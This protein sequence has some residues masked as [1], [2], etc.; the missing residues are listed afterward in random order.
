M[1]VCWPIM[2]VVRVG[3]ELIM[4]PFRLQVNERGLSPLLTLHVSCTKSPWLTGLSPNVKGTNSGN[5]KQQ[6]LQSL[7]P[8]ILFIL[9]ASC[10]LPGKYP[11]V[12]CEPNIAMVDITGPGLTDKH[13]LTKVSLISDLSVLGSVNRIFPSPYLSMF[14]SFTINFQL[15]RIHCNPCSIL[16][17]AGID[18]RVL[19][20]HRGYDQYAG[21]SAKH[22]GGETGVRGY[23]V[24]LQTP[25]DRYGH[26]ATSNDA[27]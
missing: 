25:G 1:L 16:S 6:I 10:Q 3:S 2:V 11:Y 20:I 22:S 9:I 15:C 5:S 8:F 26:V 13:K 12:S 4:S 18:S 27:G 7:L 14:F 21:L 23:S 17:P 24:T 19:I